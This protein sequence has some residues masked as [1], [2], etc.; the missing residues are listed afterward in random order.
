MVFAETPHVPYCYLRL[1]DLSLSTSYGD[2]AEHDYAC[3]PPHDASHFTTAPAD[4][5]QPCCSWIYLLIGQ[6]TDS[7]ADRYA[8]DLEISHG[9]LFMP[10]S[11]SGCR[12]KTATAASALAAYNMVHDYLLIMVNK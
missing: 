9:S 7:F 3:Y 1:S 10:A 12:A 8:R 6:G 11:M 2:A 5:D 4:E